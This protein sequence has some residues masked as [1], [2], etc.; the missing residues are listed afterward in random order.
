MKLLLIEG[1]PGSGKTTTAELICLRLRSLGLDVRWYLE[2]AADHPVHPRSVVRVRRDP[3]FGLICL[4]QWH[5][6]VKEVGSEE[7]VHVME[8]SAFQSTVRF[9]IEECQGGV[10]EYFSRFELIV[11]SLSPALVYLRPDDAIS[12]SR[13]ICGVR[14]EGWTETVSCHGSPFSTKH[15]LS[16]V[17]GMHIFWEKYSERCDALFETW[18]QTKTQVSFA[19]GEYEHHVPN[20]WEFLKQLGVVD[21]SD[22]GSSKPVETDGLSRCAPAAVAQR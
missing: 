17:E 14:G 5:R 7:T 21:G 13:Y 19:P 10:A 2:E 4:N 18:T 15:N 8:G 3:R 20:L 6:F 12:N 16:G 22:V 9:M 1:P 11:E